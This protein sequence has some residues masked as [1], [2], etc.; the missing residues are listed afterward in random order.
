MI[1]G[2]VLRGIYHAFRLRHSR[3]AAPEKYHAV[4]QSRVL[5]IDGLTAGSFTAH[6][7]RW[8]YED[9]RYDENSSLR[10]LM[11]LRLS[12]QFLLTICAGRRRC[13]MLATLSPFFCLW[14]LRKSPVDT[15][16][17]HK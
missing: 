11:L 9:I 2:S 5:R 8:R 6:I 1:V 4:I 12:V 17:A 7:R 10:A 15:L 14:S 13:L 3:L 16:E